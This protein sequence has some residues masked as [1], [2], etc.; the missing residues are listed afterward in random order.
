MFIRS[1]KSRSI[2]QF[3]NRPVLASGLRVVALGLAAAALTLTS[4]ARQ[5]VE[6]K[7]TTDTKMESAPYKIG[8]DDVIDVI[9]WKEPQLSG[10]VRVVADGTVTIP[11]VGPVPA[12][13][14]TCEQLQAD[15][16]KRLAQYTHNPNVTVRVAAPTS[17]VFY[18]L[19]EVT[20][21]GSYPLRSDEVL[22]QAL[23]Q[24]GGFTTFADQS[25]IRIVR[26]TRD[27]AVEIVVDYRQV[28]QGNLQADIPLQAGDTVTVP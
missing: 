16:T 9:V 12:E 11:L 22:S 1:T 7:V 3:W 24:A 14:L 26:R 8:K 27:K 4:C 17:Q 6:T 2:I 19:G 21:P 20:K 10:K 18:V 28:A 23:A 13:G 25:A 5:A 15:L